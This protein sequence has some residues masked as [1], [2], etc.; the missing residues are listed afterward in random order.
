MTPVDEIIDLGAYILRIEAFAEPFFG[1]A[2]VGYGVFVGAGKSIAPNIINLSSMWLLRIPLSMVAAKHM[3]LT[4]VWI[5][6]SSELIVRGTIYLLYLRS[7][8]WLNTKAMRNAI[9][10]NRTL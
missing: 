4:G 6:M 1:A 2:I 7:N 5:A 3:G 10:K 8:R 9:A